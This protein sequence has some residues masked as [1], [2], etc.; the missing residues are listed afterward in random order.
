M[1][2]QNNQPLNEE[3]DHIIGFHILSNGSFIKVHPDK[4][5]IL[6]GISREFIEIKGAPKRCR[7]LATLMAELPNQRVA[8][9]YW[10][11][12]LAIIDLNSKTCVATNQIQYGIDTLSALPDGTLLINSDSIYDIQD[13][14]I[15]LN[16]DRSERFSHF[17][18]LQDDGV[19]NN[20]KNHVIP[21]LDQSGFIAHTTW[22]QSNVKIITN[23]LKEKARLQLGPDY[24]PNNIRFKSL[25]PSNSSTIELLK[26]ISQD[27]FACITL[28]EDKYFAATRSADTHRL[29]IVRN[30]LRQSYKVN[31]HHLY[32]QALIALS[33]EYV[34]VVG[35]HAGGNSH[36]I[37]IKV[38]NL[39]GQQVNKFTLDK[40][41]GNH[42][43][44]ATPDGQLVTCS[45]TGQIAIHTLMPTKENLPK[46]HKEVEKLRKKT[47]STLVDGNILP[48]DLV[49]LITGYAG[50]FSGN[51][52]MP[53]DT[54]EEN[55]LPNHE[56]SLFSKLRSKF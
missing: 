28:C 23:Q 48:K 14:N 47:E 30:D 8:L 50:F 42:F 37:S 20:G 55:S 7:P 26:A 52:E 24:N 10:P 49:P 9:A 5:E 56:P 17:N 1:F 33:N 43:I 19:Y 21:L 41:S 32:P 13:N 16:M 15:A 2:S 51:P 36:K 18:D 3:K 39:K 12:L 54:F 6:E 38:Y 53:Q 44:A 25:T 29:H 40:T 27:Y 31:L 4:V 45:R 35:Q 34:A 11:D 22:D 46:D